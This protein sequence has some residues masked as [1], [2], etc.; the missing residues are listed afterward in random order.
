MLTRVCLTERRVSRVQS[1]PSVMTTQTCRWHEGSDLDEDLSV[2][3][4]TWAQAC[5]PFPFWFLYVRVT[6][7]RTV[8]CE[9]ECVFPKMPLLKCSYNGPL[10][11]H[12]TS[13]VSPMYFNWRNRMCVSVQ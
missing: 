5:V 13:S 4:G 9:T 2:T 10:G 7:P 12:A 8:I 3:E 11:A 6:W 1:N